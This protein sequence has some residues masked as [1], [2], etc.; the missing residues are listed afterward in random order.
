MNL[1]MNLDNKINNINVNNYN[2]N[3]NFDSNIDDINFESKNNPADKTAFSFDKLLENLQSES[4]N[5][6]DNID[7]AQTELDEVDKIYDVLIDLEDPD[8]FR[9]IKSK[10]KTEEGENNEKDKMDKIRKKNLNQ[11]AKHQSITNNSNNTNKIMVKNQ[12]SN[13]K[14][15]CSDDKHANPFDSLSYQNGPSLD[16]FLDEIEGDADELM[17]ISEEDM[18][19]SIMNK[20]KSKSNNKN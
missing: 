1:E 3:L 4:N 18:K 11:I 13:H 8:V 14:M 20:N 9:K 15:E 19:K 5:G 17:E 12:S 7:D 2:T 10:V 6:D 16:N